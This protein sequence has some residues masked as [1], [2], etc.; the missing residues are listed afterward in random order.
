[1]RHMYK[2]PTCFVRPSVYRR[3]LLTCH[4]TAA[5]PEPSKHTIQED[6]VAGL[7]LVCDVAGS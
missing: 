5:D 6:T 3:L 2:D 4:S 1:M 7:L